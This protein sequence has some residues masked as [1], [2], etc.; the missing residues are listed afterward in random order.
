[1]FLNPNREIVIIETIRRK[2]MKGIAINF[3]SLDGKLFVR[4]V[5][6][7]FL[8]FVIERNIL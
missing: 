4:M 2:F 3:V 5:Y 8:Q 6:L 7:L 1:M